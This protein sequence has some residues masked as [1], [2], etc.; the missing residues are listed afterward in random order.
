[1]GRHAR[2]RGWAGARRKD[3]HAHIRVRRDAPAHAGQL[4]SRCGPKSAIERQPARSR[5][6]IERWCRAERVDVAAQAWYTLIM[7][8]SCVPERKKGKTG[9]RKVCPGHVWQERS[10]QSTAHVG[11]LRG[12]RTS[13]LASYHGFRHDIMES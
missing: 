3:A 5:L 2:G 11:G 10:C 7:N 13:P 4:Q 12:I 8:H 9:A 1:M 6:F